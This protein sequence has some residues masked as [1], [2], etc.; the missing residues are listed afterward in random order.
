MIY[1]LTK[2]EKIKLVNQKLLSIENPEIGFYV[3]L[4]FLKLKINKRLY[5]RR[6]NLK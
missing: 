4:T 1:E 5:F 3:F 6:F 2:V